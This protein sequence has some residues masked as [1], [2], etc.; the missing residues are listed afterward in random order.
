[1]ADTAQGVFRG[2][3]LKG[4]MLGTFLLISMVAGIASGA[5]MF[6]T[7]RVGGKGLLVGQEL[8][9]LVD[10]AME[11]KLTATTAHL[12]FEEIMAGD[13][14]EDVKEVWRLLDETVFFCDAILKGGT[15]EEGSFVAST[16]PKVL[17]KVQEVR[18][19]VVKFIDSARKRYQTR[20]SASGTGSAAD[21]AFDESY[22]SI[23][24]LIDDYI[25]KNR[26]ANAITD[27]LITAGSSK[28]LL[29]DS[30]LFF[31]EL[32]SGDESIRFD[33]VLA[34]MSEAKAQLISIKSSGDKDLDEAIGYISS[35]YSVGKGEVCQ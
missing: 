1:M 30:H 11:I 21:Q 6:F 19:S 18:K 2:M 20:T 9:P 26:T 29:A 34:N 32:L 8:A 27:K 25:E 35:F 5:G 7:K 17:E 22:E 13:A 15:N 24:R 12:L 3:S 31:E 28:F 23:V 14:A 10:A 33:Q 16:D 4:K